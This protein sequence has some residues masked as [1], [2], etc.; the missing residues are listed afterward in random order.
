MTDTPSTP[1]ADAQPN[2]PT[3]LK[4]TFFQTLEL[5]I[6]M[7]GMV[8]AFVLISVG[9]QILSGLRNS[10]G[11]NPID[12]LLNGTFVT[13]RNIFNLTILNRV[14]GDHGDGHGVHHRHAPH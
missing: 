7:L 1:A 13:P 9:F 14:G 2:E 4:R 3:R 5:D 8:G 10:G 11:A 6:R 12:W